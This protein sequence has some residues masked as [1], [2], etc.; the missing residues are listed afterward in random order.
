MGK[1]S[2][3]AQML[4]R[5]SALEKNSSEELVFRIPPRPGSLCK[6]TKYLDSRLIGSLASK[7]LFSPSTGS[8]VLADRV[9]Q[10]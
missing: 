7:L 4:K 2:H 10:S 3:F 8:K 5:S 9:W 1:A 6:T